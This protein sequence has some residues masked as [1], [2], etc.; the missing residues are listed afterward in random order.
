MPATT[1]LQ[2]IQIPI[3]DLRPDPANPRKISDAELDALTRSLR[4]FGFVQPVLARHEDKIVIG[5][6]QR[7]LAARR[8]G[9]KT[10]PVIFLEVS[11]EQ[12]KL[13]NLALNKISGEWD[14]QLLAPA[15]R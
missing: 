12:A 2:I 10:V 15:A 5:G 13:L 8:L 4:E 11:D 6:H 9:M 3:A 1:D 14:E 7:L